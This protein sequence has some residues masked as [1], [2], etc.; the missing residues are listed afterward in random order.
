MKKRKTPAYEVKVSASIVSSANLDKQLS[1][2]KNLFGF[3]LEILF[4]VFGFRG[5]FRWVFHKKPSRILLNW[6][7]TQTALGGRSKITSRL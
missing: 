2:Q 3:F 4:Q 6:V 7:K 5:F 1:F